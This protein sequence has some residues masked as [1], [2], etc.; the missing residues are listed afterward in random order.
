MTDSY[1]QIILGSDSVA[2]LRTFEIRLLNPQSTESAAQGPN[3]I[4]RDRF[5]PR[6]RSS[7]LNTLNF[8]I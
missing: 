2:S 8:A 1:I 7:S 4:A 3:G 6:K 5:H